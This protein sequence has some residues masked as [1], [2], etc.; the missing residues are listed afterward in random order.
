RRQLRLLYAADM[1]QAG[2]DLIDRNLERARELVE[3]YRSRPDPLW[4]DRWRGFEWYFLWKALHTEQAKLQHS[5]TA[6]ELVITPDGTKLLRGARREN[7]KMGDVG[8]SRR[9]G[10]FANLEEPILG[11]A[12]SRDGKRL[13]ARGE[14]GLAKVWDVASRRNVFERRGHGGAQIYTVALSPDGGMVA[15]GGRDA[16][17]RM[18]KTGFGA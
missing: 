9:E 2:Q 12:L 8:E 18:W 4:D 16:A 11:L 13:A 3:R 14:R 17:T 6:T 10:V 7:I 15:N 1:R 5:T